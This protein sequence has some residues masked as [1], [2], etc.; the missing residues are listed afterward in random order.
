MRFL[1]ALAALLAAAAPWRSARATD[2][3]AT[4]GTTIT[5]K[6]KGQVGIYT[7]LGVGYRAIFPYHSNDFCG[8]STATGGAKSACTGFTPGFIDVGISYAFTNTVEVLGDVRIGLGQDFKPETASGAAPHVLAIAPGF[9][10]YVNEAGSVKWFSTVQLAIDLT[11]YSTSGVAASTDIG[12]KNV[13][14]ILVDLHRTFGIYGHVG[15]TVS[16][17]RWLSFE[18]DFG[19][20]MQV[21]FP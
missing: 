16:F 6:H 18:L 19:I 4:G 15:E 3:E 8:E 1:L 11:D 14:G 12:L 5:Y 17:V 10:F 21:R 20:G 13:N 2:K 9:K 7:Q